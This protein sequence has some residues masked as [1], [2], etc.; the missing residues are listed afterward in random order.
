M[1]KTWFH[2]HAKW[3]F[4]GKYRTVFFFFS[5]KEECGQNTYWPIHCSFITLHFHS[6][7]PTQGFC[8]YLES[9]NVP[10]WVEEMGYRSQFQMG[11]SPNHKVAVVHAC[12][13][14]IL[15]GPGRLTQQGSQSVLG[16]AECQHTTKP[17]TISNNTVR[18][19]VRKYL[20]RLANYSEEHFYLM[21][22]NVFR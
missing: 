2:L 22:I 14:C 21:P 8:S 6:C 16:S 9:V 20:L 1:N 15:K 5:A 4:H 18:P 13:V 3:V 19:S 10:G 17:Q 7:D 11:F 12:S